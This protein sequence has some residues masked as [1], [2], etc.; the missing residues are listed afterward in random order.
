MLIQ[1]NR[2]QPISRLRFLIF[3]NKMFKDL[4]VTIE[5]HLEA[6]GLL[7]QALL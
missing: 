7:A 5:E 1:E 3:R 4:I 2:S 6:I